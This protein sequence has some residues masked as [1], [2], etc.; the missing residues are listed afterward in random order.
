MSA[1]IDLTVTFANVQTLPS[2]LEQSSAEDGGIQLKT[3]AKGAFSTTPVLWKLPT[4]IKAS[5]ISTLA[6]TGTLLTKLYLF[7]IIDGIVYYKPVVGALWLPLPSTTLP[8]AYA[9]LATRADLL[10]VEALN[11]FFF[12]DGTQHEVGIAFVFTSSGT[13]TPVLTTLEAGIEN[14][15]QDDAVSLTTVTGK[16]LVHDSIY[17]PSTFKVALNKQGL[18]YKTCALTMEPITVEVDEDTGVWEVSLPDTDNMDESAAWLFY[19]TPGYPV[20]R[21]VPATTTI[22]FSNLTYVQTV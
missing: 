21:K 8:S 18:M 17:T 19:F 4:S 22:E 11:A 15:P 2:T 5:L 3:G 6:V 13:A 16:L 14:E 20:A 10:N 1:S 7:P 12:A 9:T